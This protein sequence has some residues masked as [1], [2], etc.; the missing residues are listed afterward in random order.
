MA[1]V[2]SV[3][4]SASYGFR[5]IAVVLYQSFVEYESRYTTAGFTATA[6][7]T[8]QIQSRMLEGPVFVA[9]LDLAIVGTVSLVPK[10]ESLYE[11]DPHRACGAGVSRKP[12]VKRSGTPGWN[13]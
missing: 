9:L 8:D 6:I 13:R 1:G 7:T 3:A 12:G 10:G 4:H 11:R 2:I 5:S